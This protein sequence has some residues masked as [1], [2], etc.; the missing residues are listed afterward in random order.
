LTELETNSNTYNDFRLTQVPQ[1]GDSLAVQQKEIAMDQPA[2]L[3]SD[4]YHDVIDRLAAVR[5][6]FNQPC[7]RSAIIEILGEIGNIWPASIY[8]G[9][10]DE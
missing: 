9:D 2:Y 7:V 8:S 10:D 1:I 4:I 3:H 5:P 6:T